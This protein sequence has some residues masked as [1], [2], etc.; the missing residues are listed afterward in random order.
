M[1]IS[2]SLSFLI[3][4]LT[5]A[6]ANA[7]MTQQLRGAVVD[8]V[9]QKPLAGA[10]VTLTSQ[11]RSTV[12]DSNGNFKFTN[13]PLGRQTLTISHVG[14]KDLTQDNIEVEAGK[15]T[16][17]TFP[18]E[19]APHT[20]QV[21]EVKAT[22]R[23][24]QPLNE[25]S[26]VSARTF[27]VEETNKYAA[28]VNDPLRMATSFAGVF[29]PYDGNNDIVIRGNSPLGLLW[30]MEGVEIPNPN[31]FSNPASSGGGISILSAQLLANSDFLTGAFPAQYGDALSGVFD[32]RL[33]KGN[34]EKNEYT[35]QAGVLGLDAAAEGPLKHGSYL[36]D[37]RY[38]TLG[39]LSS[40]G[41]DVG[42]GSTYF[43]D[44]S[45]NVALPAGN[46]G[47]LN[48]FGFGGLSNST[49]T[50]KKDSTKWKNFDDRFQSTYSGPS[51]FSGLAH[52]IFLD[53]RTSLHSVLGF[54]YTGLSNKDNYMQDN[55]TYLPFDKSTDK[56][57]KLTL[58]SNLDH[59]FDADNL[60]RTGY[61]VDFIHYNYLQQ[62]RQSTTEPYLDQVNAGGS[63]QTVEAYTEWQ[64]RSIPHFQFNAGLHYLELLYN[65]TYSIEP[66]VSVKWEADSR[67]SF[68]LG[69]GLH[70]QIQQLGV[71]FAQDTNTAGQTYRPNGNLGLTKAHHIVLS[72]THKLEQ[73]LSFKTEVY[74]QYLFN[75][76]V[77]ANDTN[78][79]STLNINESDYVSDPLT[80]KGTGRNYGL[81]LSLEKFLSNN[82]YYLVNGAL[83]QSKYTA[84]DG[85]ERNTMF[86]GNYLFNGVAG[87]DYTWLDKAG[88]KKVFGVNIKLIYAGGYRDSPIDEAASALEA[89]TVYY[90]KEAYTLQNPA[91]FRADLRLS[92]K[93][94]Y[95]HVTTTLS[96]DLQNLTGTRN[97]Y[98]QQYD[99]FQGKIVNI[100]QT[101]LIP[102][103]NYKVEF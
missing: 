37:Y 49:V 4:L 100:Y 2:K 62:G 73:N 58:T 43:Q 22:S 9:L 86:N 95:R 3:L 88:K 87:K 56:T 57:T 48:L 1:N 42:S 46:A 14:F 39:L 34:T 53:N 71:Y 50:P 66:R 41:V 12:T 55:Y 33:R 72:Y 54:S 6:I 11:N 28:A 10:T 103:L 84:L 96:L 102:V 27:S 40:I 75:V 101:G 19:T 31:H 77:N 21:A 91:Y 29:A 20:E 61:I 68:A 83:Y 81:E 85:I 70:S 65:H 92:L 79:F 36:V 94:D 24:N 47:N 60:L 13:I 52:T 18:M 8:G 38:S 30:R 78:T 80:N 89:K 67:N 82:L 74:Y 35:L 17:L 69:Y 7:Q 5:T 64:G 59:R 32:L 98:D 93:K 26:V 23:R 16:I 76:P 15:E 25:M 90:Q 44:L 45:Y 97:I 63:T 99:P 51:G